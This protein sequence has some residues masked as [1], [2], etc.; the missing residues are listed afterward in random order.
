MTPEP[1]RLGETVT[2]E[3]CGETQRATIIGWDYVSVPPAS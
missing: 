1:I 3:R 2:F